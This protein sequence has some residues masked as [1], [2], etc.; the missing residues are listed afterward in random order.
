MSNRTISEDILRG[1]RAVLEHHAPHLV[2]TINDLVRTRL[3]EGPS[4]QRGSSIHGKLTGNIPWEQG[5]P[6]LKAL[7][8]VQRDQGYQ[9]KFEGRQ[10]NL[11]IACWRHFAEPQQIPPI[12]SAAD[13]E[14][15]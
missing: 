2:V 1:I 7:Q 13:L 10:I 6:I 14:S 8:A 12:E 4:G 3:A 11:L 5:E 9:A 15:H